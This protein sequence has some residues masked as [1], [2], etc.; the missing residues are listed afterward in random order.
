MPTVNLPADM[1][2]LCGFYALGKR[3]S[4]TPAP[5]DTP[6]V[7]YH[8]LAAGPILIANYWSHSESTIITDGQVHIFEF[9]VPEPTHVESVHAFGFCMLDCVVIGNQRFPNEHQ[10]PNPA[11]WLLTPSRTLMPSDN[12]RVRVIVR[13]II[14]H[15][16][17]RDDSKP[18]EPSL[19][20]TCGHDRKLHGPRIGCMFL[21]CDCMQYCDHASPPVEAP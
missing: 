5:P 21:D 18:I 1:R 13:G 11:L 16:G 2:A 4:E 8:L 17:I 14:E 12:N 9:H 7:R 15:F 3:V 20:A 10:A 6:Q 19:C